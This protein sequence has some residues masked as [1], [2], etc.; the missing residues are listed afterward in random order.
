MSLLFS[1]PLDELSE[2]QY[3]LQAIGTADHPGVARQVGFLVYHTLR[4]KGSQP[5]YPDWTLARERV[6]FLELKTEAGKVSDAQKKWLGALLAAGAEVYLARPRH[7]EQLTRILAYHGD[8]FLSRDVVEDAT[9][10]RH[11]LRLELAA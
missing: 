2:K 10:L 6:I 3:E 11:Q 7:L 8:P 9:A 4:S 1:T 5:G